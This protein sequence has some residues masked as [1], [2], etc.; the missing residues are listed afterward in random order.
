MDIG[1]ARQTAQS[2]I[3]LHGLK[4]QAVAEHR[5]EEAR[6]SGNTDALDQWQQI[7]AMICE[8]KRTKPAAHA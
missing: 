2:L 3:R 6:L 8:L 1:Q 5:V 7:H 4:A